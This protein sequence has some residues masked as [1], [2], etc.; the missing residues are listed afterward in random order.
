MATITPTT[1]VN[2]TN[3]ASNW[4]KGVSSNAQK[5]LQKYLA[6]KRLFNADPSG[7]QAAWVAGVQAAQA[8]NS[9]QNGMASADVTAAANNASQYGVNNYATSGTSKAYKFAAKAPNLAQAITSSM[10]AANATPRGP[11][12][13]QAN[14]TRMTTFAST[15]HSFKGKI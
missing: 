6:P 13:S 10:N 9:Y 14:I 4:G 12:G 7:A 15:M 8:T 11:S 1:T 2:A 5:W 3:M